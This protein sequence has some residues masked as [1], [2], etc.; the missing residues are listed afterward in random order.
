[1][2]FQSKER[3]IKALKDKGVNLPCPRCATLRFEVVGQTVLY[4]NDDPL[5]IR[6]GGDGLPSAIIACSHC[7]FIMLHALGG[8]NLMPQL[9][10]DKQS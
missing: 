2:D 8:L 4:L 6:I 1:M 9:N 3:I 5:N 7:G 10:E